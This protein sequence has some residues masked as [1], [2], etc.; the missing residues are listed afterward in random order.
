MTIFTCQLD[1]IW[2]ELKLPNGHTY[3]EFLFCFKWEDLLLIW[4][5]EVETPASNLGH[6]FFG[7]L[8]KDMEEEL[9]PFSSLI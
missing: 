3:E 9:S 4:T 6:A 2:N 8:Y 1:Y 5:F 7:N